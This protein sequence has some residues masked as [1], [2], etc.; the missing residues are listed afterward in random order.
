MFN[1]PSHR[2]SDI[3]QGR[4]LNACFP[5]QDPRHQEVIHFFSLYFGWIENVNK[6]YINLGLNYTMI[7][8]GRRPCSEHLFQTKKLFCVVIIIIII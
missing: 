3:F 1:P 6:P 2:S 8:H 7:S 4:V 5:Y